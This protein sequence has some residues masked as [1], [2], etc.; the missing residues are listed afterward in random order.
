MKQGR[1]KLFATFIKQLFRK[2]KVEVPLTPEEKLQSNNYGN[3]GG[4]N[5]PSDY[6]RGFGG[7]AAEDHL[8]RVPRDNP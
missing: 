7:I 4:L 3:A 2:V 6:N 5:P 8:M 1:Y